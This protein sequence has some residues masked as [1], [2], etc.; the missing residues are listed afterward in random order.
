MCIE[1]DCPLSVHFLSH[2]TWL[3]LMWSGMVMMWYN[4]NFLW[5]NCIVGYVFCPLFKLSFSASSTWNIQVFLLWRLRQGWCFGVLVPHLCLLIFPHSMTGRFELRFW[6][7]WLI[8]WS[9]LEVESR[10]HCELWIWRVHFKVG[11][12]LPAQKNWPSYNQ[13]ERKASGCLDRS[14]QCVLHVCFVCHHSGLFWF[15]VE[16]EESIL[17]SG[18]S[19]LL[20]DSVGEVGNGI[21]TVFVVKAKVKVD[22]EIGMMTK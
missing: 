9:N 14:I 20:S 13:I 4:T 15:L 8:T 12:H 17:V 2:S 5:K 10:M 3:K 19:N 7:C 11:V 16:F 6:T 1:I 18:G 21:A 22:W